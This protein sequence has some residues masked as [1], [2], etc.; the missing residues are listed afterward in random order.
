MGLVEGLAVLLV[1]LNERKRWRRAE[2]EHRKIENETS[3]GATAHSHPPL[4]T[5]THIYTHATKRAK[6]KAE[7]SLPRRP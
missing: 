1:W 7:A 6:A 4:P 2:K 3:D 5:P